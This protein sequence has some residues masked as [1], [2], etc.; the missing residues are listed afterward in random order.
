MESVFLVS[1]Y[2]MQLFVCCWQKD[3]YAEVKKDSLTVN[4]LLVQSVGCLW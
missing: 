3:L 4:H 2:L 1:I